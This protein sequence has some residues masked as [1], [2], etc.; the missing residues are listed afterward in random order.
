VAPV[1]LFV[2]QAWR[3]NKTNK[4][5]LNAFNDTSPKGFSVSEAESERQN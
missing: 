3:N 5:K 1:G 4:Q 2:A